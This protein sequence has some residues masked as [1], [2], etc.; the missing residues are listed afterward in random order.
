MS[1][2]D[3]ALAAVISLLDDVAVQI[4]ALEAEAELL[5]HE[6][7]DP[8]GSAANMRRKAELLSELPDTLEPAMKGL[9]KK[10]R[11]KVERAADGFSR[12]GMMALE[13]GSV[14]WMRNLLYPEDYTEGEPNDLEQFVDDLASGEGQ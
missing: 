12:R 5:L 9:D 13:Q 10:L 1:N 14:F 8:E 6:Q 2:S 7:D 4:R 11:D 3:T